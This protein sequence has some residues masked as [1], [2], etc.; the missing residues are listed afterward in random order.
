MTIL[1]TYLF[2][3]SL[4]CY[5]IPDVF[6]GEDKILIKKSISWRNIMQDSWEQNFRTKNRSQVTLIGCS[7]SSETRHGYNGQTSWLHRLRSACTY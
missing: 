5:V 4:V 2:W 1:F 3:Q 7:R 6:S